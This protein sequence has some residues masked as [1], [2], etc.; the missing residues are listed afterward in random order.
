MPMPQLNTRSIS[1]SATLPCS[2]SQAKS[3]GAVQLP[4]SMRARELSGRTRGTFSTRPPPV[5]CARPLTGIALQELQHGFHVDARRLE[6][7]L[8]QRAA[9]EA[10][11]T[12]SA[13]RAPTILRISE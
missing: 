6:Q 4:R 11:P 3:G 7:H 12:R 5:M 9:V 13:R 10:S 1:A 2:W 8:A